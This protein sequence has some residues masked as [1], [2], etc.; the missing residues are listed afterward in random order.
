MRTPSR[1]ANTRGVLT[2]T[3]K[4]SIMPNSTARMFTLEL[5]ESVPGLVS[6]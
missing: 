5:I 4:T 3:A 2:F 6:R 1:S